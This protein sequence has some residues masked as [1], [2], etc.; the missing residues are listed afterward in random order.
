MFPTSAFFPAEHARPLADG[1]CPLLGVAPGRTGSWPR[2]PAPCSLDAGRTTDTLGSQSR[3]KPLLSRTGYLSPPPGRS[4]SSVP[5]KFLAT[6]KF[7]AYPAARLGDPGVPSGLLSPL[8]PYQRATSTGC[9]QQYSVTL[10]GAR[11]TGA[12]DD[13]PA[14]ART[15]A[16][17]AQVY[18]PLR[19]GA[20][21][22]VYLI[23]S[24]ITVARPIIVPCGVRLQVA[25]GKTLTITA[26]PRVTCMNQVGR[27]GAEERVGQRDTATVPCPCWGMGSLDR[28]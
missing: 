27:W 26:Q 14:I 22:S 21:S 12:V 7:L 10:R 17:S 9:P 2:D 19:S 3:A 18:F 4:Y 5:S 16:A 25:A 6:T 20:T 23:S 28:V 15:A 1:S 24:S 8:Y 11:G 13:S